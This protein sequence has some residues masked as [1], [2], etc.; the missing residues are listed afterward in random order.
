MC[1][2]IAH[3]KRGG[4]LATFCSRGVTEFLF[5]GMLVLNDRKSY[6]NLIGQVFEQLR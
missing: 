2:G 3:I 4:Q 5:W 1:L 6:V